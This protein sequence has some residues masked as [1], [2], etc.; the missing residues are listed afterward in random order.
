MDALQPL[1]P[2][3]KNCHPSKAVKS[4]N[5]VANVLFKIRSDS[6]IGMHIVMQPP[7]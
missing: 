1:K 2:M 4:S 3:I 7:P 6:E 5:K